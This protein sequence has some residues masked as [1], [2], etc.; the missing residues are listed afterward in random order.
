MHYQVT[1]KMIILGIF[2]LAWSASNTSGAEIVTTDDYG[3]K[4]VT[5]EHIVKTAGNAIFLIFEGW[6]IIGHE[7]RSFLPCSHNK[8]L[9][10]LGNSPALEKVMKAYE[11]ARFAKMPYTPI[12]MT[13]AGKI[14]DPPSDGFGADYEEAFLA[15]RLLQVFPQGNCK[16]ELIYL[17]TPLPGECVTSPLRI[18]GYA[19]GKWFF[20]GDFPVIL[21]DSDGKVIAKGYATAKD[22]WM[23]DKIVP[24]ES[25]IEFKMPNSGGRGVLR[26]KKDNPTDL[27]E[28]DNQLEI[29]IHF[30]CKDSIGADPWQKITFDVS[31]L[32][33]SGLYGSPGGKTGAVL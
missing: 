32:D 27:P 26:L 11:K 15:T 23:T 6:V 30:V 4:I 14:V 13:L 20:E 9:W 7:V 1:F 3:Q 33:E 29:E 5:K 17:D 25:E 2:L 21:N 16:D 8:E 28:H 10:L 19:R 12:F 24:F 31:K 22:E 18:R